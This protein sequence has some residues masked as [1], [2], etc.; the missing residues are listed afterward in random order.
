MSGD[1]VPKKKKRRVLRLAILLACFA[2]FISAAVFLILDLSSGDSRVLGLF[3]PRV[4]G[5]TVDELNFDVGRD[6]VFAYMNGSVASAGTLGVQVLDA[7]GR[8]TLRDPFRMT[9]P[10]ISSSEGRF[11]AFDIGGTAVRVFSA[12]RILTAIEAPGAVVSVSINQN[13]W[14]CIVTQEGGGFRGAVMVYNSSGS[15][16]YRVTM[17]TGFVISAELSPDNQYL[18]IL[19]LTE[20]G[21]RITYYGIDSDHDEPDYLFDLRGGLILDIKYLSNTDILAISTD[22]LILVEDFESGNVLYSFSD[23]R[24]GGYTFDGDFLALHLYDYGI[25]HSGRVLTLLSDGT[26]LGDIVLFRDVIS[27]SAVD[28]SLIILQSDGLSFFNEELEEFPISED[29]LSAAGAIRVIAVSEEVAL[30]ANDNSAVIIRK[31]EE[32]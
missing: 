16:V 18:A 1:V 26:I 15:I 7:G 25:G 22:S 31:E 23:K 10:A 9:Q 28:N 11:I 12:S 8:E 19:N 32:R 4:T 21:S 29:N 30:A 3:S 24:L 2:I 14:F 27:M 20:T 13:G 5:I 17:G 6:R